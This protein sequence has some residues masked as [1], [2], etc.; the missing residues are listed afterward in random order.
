MPILTLPKAK[1]QLGIPDAD[2]SRDAQLT[3]WLGGITAAVENYLNE[4]TAQREITERIR[5]TGRKRFRLWHTPVVSLTSLVSADGSTT[6]D[7]SSFD[8][9][10]DSGVVETLSGYGPAGLVKATYQAGYAVVPQNIVQGA[11]VILQHVW[12]TQ[13]GVGTEY[14]GVVGREEQVRGS[15]YANFIIPRKALEWLGPPRPVVA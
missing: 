3:D 7:T 11:L 9:D 13:R 14:G 15:T 1:A 4:V 10:P 8:V 12:E 6:W 2:T 5:L